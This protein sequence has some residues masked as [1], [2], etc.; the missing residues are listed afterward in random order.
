MN[1][2]SYSHISYRIVTSETQQSF[3]PKFLA[4][5]LESDNGMVSIR[6]VTPNSSHAANTIFY[7]AANIISSNYPVRLFIA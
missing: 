1:A 4:G 5:L 3:G 6:G 2:I 7:T